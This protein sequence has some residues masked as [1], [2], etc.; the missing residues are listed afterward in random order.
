MSV[1]RKQSAFLYRDDWGPPGR[2]LPLL[3][4]GQKYIDQLEYD[5]FF[6]FEQRTDIEKFA[7]II[8]RYAKKDHAD[9]TGLIIDA[10]WQPFYRTF[11]PFERGRKLTVLLVTWNG[12]RANLMSIPSLAAGKLQALREL[13]AE[14]QITPIDIW[15]NP[16]FYRNQEGKHK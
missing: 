12:Y 16:G 1:L 13:D 8:D 9:E 2:T 7:Q 3:D 11:T 4:N 5:L 14:W 6:E 10:W 15:V